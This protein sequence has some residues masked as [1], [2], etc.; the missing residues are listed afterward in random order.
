MKKFDWN[1]ITIIPDTLSTIASRSEINPLQNGKLP[2][3]TAPMDMVIDEN[4]ISEF[5]LNNV[6]VCLPR[7]VKFDSL[8]ND[9]YFYSYGLDEIIEL[10]ESDKELPKKVLID[11]ANGHMLKLWEISKRIKEKY[12]NNIELMVGNIANPETYRKY[13]E[14]GVDWIRCGIGGGSACTTSANVS[15]HFPM[16]SLVNECYEISKEFDNPTKILADG[17]FRSFSDIIKAL[18]LGAHACMLGGIF[19]K[20]LESCSDNF[21]KDSVGIFHLIDEERAIANFNSGIDV[22]K[23]YRGMSTK[24]VQK[25]WNR[26]ELKTGEGISKY[27][28]VE[29]TLS[30]WREN[31]TDYL[32][33]AMSYSNSR[34]LEEFIGQANWVKI[35]QNSFDRFNK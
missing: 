19:N 8:K 22:W 17:G 11:V 35:S 15:I 29:Y 2:I 34:T 26:K 28:K 7:N 18:A 4:N 12:G 13:C 6:N 10:F 33:S 27:N 32:R 24:E 21:L 30:G 23:Y 14:I 5:E 25:S 9:N 1:D 3:F 31:F 16:A 20:C